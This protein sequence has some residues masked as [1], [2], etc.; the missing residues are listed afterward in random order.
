[1][2]LL[3]AILFMALIFGLCFAVDK[4]FAR[5][6]RNKP[7]HKSGKSVRPNRLY[8]AFGLLLG[9]LG[10]AAVITGLND[11]IFL[12]VAGAVVLVFG[13]LLVAYYL[14]FGIYY[15]DETLLYDPFF[16]KKKTYAYSDIVGQRLYVI[17]GGSVIVELHMCDGDALSI[18]SAM[19][20]SL[21]FLNHAFA[22]WCRQTGRDPEHCE[23][24]DPAAFRWFPTEEDT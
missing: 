4:G 8:A 11:R 10:I 5:I 2:K 16:K 24:H 15:D 20:G 14:S 21:D 19:P 22:V 18:Q 23:F 1:M 6:F 13:V 3:P 12:T 9:V 17:T 7:Q